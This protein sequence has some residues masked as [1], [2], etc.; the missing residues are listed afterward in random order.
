MPLVAPQLHE[1]G[2]EETRAIAVDFQGKLD[3][4]TSPVEKLTGTPT[5][6]EVGGTDLTLAS[7]VVSTGALTINGATVGIGE[8]VQFTCAATG[9]T[10]G[11]LYSITIVCGT[12]ASQT[13]SGS[14]RVKVL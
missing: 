2:I 8:A 3:D 12:D 11:K 14:V 1:I 6:T 7:K 4:T 13:V 10:S 9:A 5:I